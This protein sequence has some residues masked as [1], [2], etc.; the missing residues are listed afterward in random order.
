MNN[1]N[2]IS[3]KERSLLI[4]N[5]ANLSSQHCEM[6]FSLLEFA[7]L[8]LTKRQKDDLI[9]IQQSFREMRSNADL[10]YKKKV[11]E[12]TKTS[13]TDI[14]ILRNLIANFS[15]ESID[16]FDYLSKLCKDPT[17]S[18]VHLFCNHM[19]TEQKLIVE[20][21]YSMSLN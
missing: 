19:L 11:V 12:L 17:Y 7:A 2:N 14:I 16:F 6:L 15:R 4:K 9:I 8:S 13:K 1:D 20:R 10:I 5:Y 21:V 3:I 18:K